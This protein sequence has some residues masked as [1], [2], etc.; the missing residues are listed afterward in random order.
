MKRQRKHFANKKQI[1]NGILACIL[2]YFVFHA[3][4]GNRGILAFFNLSRKITEAEQELENVRVERLDMEHKVQSLKA[5]SLDPDMLDEHARKN[6]GIAGKKE[7]AFVP[8]K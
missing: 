6:L 1:I 3:I 8:M 7:K 5:E 2:V 4:Y